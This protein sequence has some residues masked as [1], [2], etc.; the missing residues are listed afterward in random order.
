MK[1]IS[2]K[3]ITEIQSGA[4]SISCFADMNADGTT[5]PDI[6][7]SD[8]LNSSK[9]INGVNGKEGELILSYE[10][11]TVGELKDND[12]VIELENDDVN[13]YLIEN[14]DLIYTNG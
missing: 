3:T 13:K 14:R 11:L 10:G 9:Q 4:I 2:S 5:F 1:T 6:Y 12:L 7:Q 8:I